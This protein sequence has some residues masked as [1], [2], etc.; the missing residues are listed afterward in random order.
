[1]RADGSGERQITD[2]TVE[3]NEPA[4]SP[5]GRRIAFHQG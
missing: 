5:R 3:D 1:M 2:N 4:W